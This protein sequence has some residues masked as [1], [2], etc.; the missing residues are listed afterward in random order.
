MGFRF[1]W[2]G[3][4][5]KPNEHDTFKFF[6]FAIMEDTEFIQ[7]EAIK[8]GIFTQYYGETDFTDSSDLFKQYPPSINISEYTSVT[9]E[10]KIFMASKGFGV[11]NAYCSFFF[12]F[13]NHSNKIITVLPFGSNQDGYLFK[14][15]GRFMTNDEIKN[16]VGKD[17]QTY[18]FYKTQTYLS[19][20]ELLEHVKVE[21]LIKEQVV[22]RIRV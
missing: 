14:G 7:Y 11:R 15:V 10:V 19:K 16:R 3:G 18:R 22:R 8:R 13:D 21:S 1:L 2:N 4:V 12:R 20:T 6:L 17:S 9:P 5:H